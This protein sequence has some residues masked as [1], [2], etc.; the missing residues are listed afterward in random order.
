M[1]AAEID[2]FLSELDA[3][4][5]R[6]PLL[7]ARIMVRWDLPPVEA[8][9]VRQRVLARKRML[10]RMRPREAGGSSTPP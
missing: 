6:D 9:N 10:A 2:K 4:E 5:L 7:P 1:N 3:E 8:E